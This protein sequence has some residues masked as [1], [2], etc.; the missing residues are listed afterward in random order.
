MMLQKDIEND[1]EPGAQADPYT[2]NPLLIKTL[3]ID[4]CGVS[5]EVFEQL[6]L[7]IYAQNHICAIHY[8]NYNVLGN[9]SAKVLLR[10]CERN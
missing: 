2:E 8:I 6:L 3:I 10:I 4:D 7:G 9:K 1:R 5:D